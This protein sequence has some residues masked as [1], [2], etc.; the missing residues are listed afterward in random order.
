MH[1]E[2]RR[3]V[4]NYYPLVFVKNLKRYRLRFRRGRFGFRYGNLNYFA[5]SWCVRGF[6]HAAIDSDVARVD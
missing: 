2:P 4:D 1:Y 6:D 3:L 5:G